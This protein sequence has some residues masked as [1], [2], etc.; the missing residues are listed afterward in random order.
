MN[1]TEILSQFDIGRS[2]TQIAKGMGLWTTQV[3]R[4][5]KRN[6]RKISDG[7]GPNHSGWKGG[8]GIKSGYWTVYNPTHPRALA[9]GRVFEHILVAE[10]KLGRFISK[11]E[12]I[13][14]ID[15]DRLNNKPE[16]LYVCR[17][18][19]EHMNLHYSLEE[20]ARESYRQGKLGFKNGRYYWK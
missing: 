18:N 1:E 10:K 3:T 19:K 20:I 5:L 11:K 7:K 12:P 2:A 6:G 16:N 9:I 15:F 17:D 13:H 4:I 8:R 14:H